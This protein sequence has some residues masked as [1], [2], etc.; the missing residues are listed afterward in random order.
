MDGPHPL[1]GE[2]RQHRWDE[3]LGHQAR[4]GRT[5]EEGNLEEELHQRTVRAQAYQGFAGQDQEG[6]ADEEASCQA[7]DSP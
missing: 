5:P 4:H 3:D 2:E 1:A 7:G 6:S